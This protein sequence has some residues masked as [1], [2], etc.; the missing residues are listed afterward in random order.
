MLL[1]HEGILEEKSHCGLTA[2][3]S[4]P[5]QGHNLSLE[6]MSRQSFILGGQKLKRLGTI[7]LDLY[8]L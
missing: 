1:E 7:G 8:I 6:G 4:C 2:H 3:Q 5:H